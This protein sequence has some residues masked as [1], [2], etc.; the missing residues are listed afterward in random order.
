MSLN[1]A[2][3]AGSSGLQAESSALAAISNDIANVNTVGFKGDDIDFETLVTASAGATF[4]AGGVSTTTQQLVSQQGATTQTSSPTDLAITGQGMFVTS[5]QPTAVGGNAEAEFTRAGSFSPDANGFLKNTAGL[6]L[7]GYPADAQG[8]INTTS[9]SINTLQPINVTSIAGQVSATTAA[10]INAN[11]DANQAISPQAAAAALAPPG[12]GA[13]NALTNSMAAYNPATNTGTPPDFT[14]QIPISDS[15]GGSR[16]VQ[17]DMLKTATPNVWDAEIQA[18]P[19]SDV[20]G[21][22]GLAPGQ[23]A[24][25]TITFNADGSVASTTLP[26]SLTFGASS[27]AAPAG[28]A[29]N[30]APSLGVAAQSV[31]LGLGAPG[32]TGTMTQFASSS[33]V[34][35]I[36]TNGTPFGNLSSVTIGQTGLVTATFDNGTSRQIAQVALATFPNVNGLTAVNGDAYLQSQT[37]GDFSLKTAGTGGAGTLSSSTLESSTVDLSTEFTNLI[38][39]QQA[40]DASSKVISTAD[41]MTQ[42]LLQVIQG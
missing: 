30:W 20:V 9:T 41:Q 42:A 39:A 37:S 6:Y 34:Q 19:A 12:A 35:S 36:D 25:G 26:A 21:G 18:V 24:T 32:S 2:M 13:Y 40:Y 3:T 4:Q 27:A 38:I 10:S 1:S 22:P 29:V 15:L 5:T 33:V 28:T 17:V 31:T 14:M 23:I 11:L 16:T 8:V 7:L